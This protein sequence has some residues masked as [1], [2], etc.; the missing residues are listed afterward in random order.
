MGTGLR[1]HSKDGWN[2]LA[3]DE[4]W[5]QEFQRLDDW[6]KGH[7]GKTVVSYPSREVR[8]VETPHGVIYL[9]YIRALTDAGLAHQEW[10]S[11]AK[12]VFRPSRALATWR[13]SQKLLAAGFACPVPVLAARRRLKGY[14]NDIFASLE[15]PRPN[16]W[17]EP[18]DVTEL[19]RILAEETA[20]FHEA[21][22]AHGDFILRNLCLN[23]STRHLIFLDNDRTWRPLPPFRGHYQRRNL[24]QMAYSLLRR[25]EDVAVPHAF[26]RE[27]RCLVPALSERAAAKI[28][29]GAETRLAHRKKT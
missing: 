25:F 13:I 7:P 26:L 8:R 3:T 27:Y 22:F 19:V 9:K 4:L 1:F 6:L 18:G 11:W 21:G 23:P 29:R 14:P 10:F 5:Q 2:G 17:D 15:I 28:L 20:R 12:W 16:L 24:A